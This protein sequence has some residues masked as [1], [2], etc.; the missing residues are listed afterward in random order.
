[1]IGLT[2]GIGSG[3][4][5]VARLLAERGALV[6]DADA[7]AREVVE[8]GTPGLAAVRTRFGAGVVRSDGSLDRAALGAIVFADPAARRDLEA[9][10]HPLIRERTRGI[11]AAAP[12]GT[13]VVHDIPLLV[14][15]G[16]ASNYHLVVTVDVDVEERVRRLV[17]SRGLAEDDARARIAHQ[18]SEAERRAVADVVI[19]NN[20]APDAVV[21]QVD[22]LWRRLIAF[23]GNLGAG[24]PAVPTAV[25]TEPT[26]A[27]ERGAGAAGATEGG[28]AATERAAAGATERGAYEAQ[29]AVTADAGSTERDVSGVRA[30]AVVRVLARVAH[31]LGPVVGPDATYDSIRS[32]DAP[33]TGAG[34]VDDPVADEVLDLVV[35]VP[36]LE[37]VP[38]DRVGKAL[39]LAG[40]V[41]T[42]DGTYASADPGLPARLRVLAAR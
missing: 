10:T 21:P 40:L 16:V 39:V 4:S 15:T 25:G 13:V 7:L 32:A 3:K 42:T 20:G 14:E 2:G 6:V 23:E 36:D 19:D 18:A 38:W 11:I 1:M 30:A 28:V 27:T 31:R 37:S 34:E 24:R 22:A 8:P 5:T 17:S 26:G 9:I 35:R 41:E 29:A 12:P 33:V